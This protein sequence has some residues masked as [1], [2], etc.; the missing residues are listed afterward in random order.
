MGGCFAAVL[1]AE[2]D[3]G[4]EGVCYVGGEKAEDELPE[5]NSHVVRLY[6]VPI[7]RSVTGGTFVQLKK[8]R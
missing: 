7:V 1:D 4:Q 2:V 8:M 3:R 6:C 5:R